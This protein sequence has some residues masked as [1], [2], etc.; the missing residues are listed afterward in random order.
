MR[1]EPSERPVA[2]GPY[3]FDQAAFDEIARDRAFP[4]FD[5]SRYYAF[6]FS[7]GFEPGGSDP[8]NAGARPLSGADRGWCVAGRRL[9]A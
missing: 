2:F 7:P 1:D 6:E 8:G 3:T 5:L 4:T 9:D